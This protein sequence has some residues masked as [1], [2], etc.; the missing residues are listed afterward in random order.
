MPVFCT[1]GSYNGIATAPQMPFRFGKEE[2]PVFHS[3]FPH[4]FSSQISN[5]SMDIVCNCPLFLICFA[6]TLQ[7]D[8]KLGVKRTISTA[9]HY[10]L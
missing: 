2:I 8:E 7:L 6:E 9:F 10:G 1:V 5:Q 4:F 3:K